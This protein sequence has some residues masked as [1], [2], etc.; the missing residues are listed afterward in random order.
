MGEEPIRILV[1]EDDE[2]LRSVLCQVLESEGYEVATAS[3][4]DSAI[5]AARESAFDLVVADIRMEG[6]SGLDALEAIKTDQP[7]VRSLVI[8]GYSTEADSIR[9]I[10]LGVND[11]LTKPFRLDKFTDSINAIVARHRIERKRQ[12]ERDNTRISLLWVTRL[13][14]LIA[15]RCSGASK[16]E[17]LDQQAGCLAE[18]LGLSAA[19]AEQIR[20]ATL[21]CVLK[22]EEESAKLPEPEQLP[23][24]LRRILASV[25][26][27]WDGSGQPEGLKHRSIPLESRV[28]AVLLAEHCGELKEKQNLCKFDPEI[29]SVLGST[30]QSEQ[31]RDELTP[32][33]RRGLLS[34]G[35]ALHEAGQKEQALEAFRSLARGS[36]V[37][38]ERAEA[39]ASLAQLTESEEFAEQA[40]G[41][42]ESLGPTVSAS[43]LLRAA[44]AY[45]RGTKSTDWLKRALSLFREMGDGV[46]Q[47]T[48]VF[49]L[50]RITDNVQPSMFEKSS[51]F[52]L[53]P[54][55]RNRL[56]EVSSWLMPY[57]LEREELSAPLERLAQRILWDTQNILPQILKSGR[58]NALQRQR[59]LALVKKAGHL[60]S[61]AAVEC[62]LNDPDPVVKQQAQ[63]LVAQGTEPTAGSFLLIR[64]LGPFEVHVGDQRIQ[65]SEWKTRK[66]KF[67]AAWLLAR[68][69]NSL[70]ED[71]ILDQFWPDELEKGKQ[72][73][74]SATSAIRRLLKGPNKTP[75][76]PI[77]RKLGTVGLNPEANS[78]IDVRELQSLTQKARRELASG[79]SINTS[80]FR[81]IVELYRG[82]FLEECYMD[83]AAELRTRISRDTAEVLEA[84]A[85]HAQDPESV[86][87]FSSKLVEIDPW[88]QEARALAFSSLLELGR[89]QRV[90]RQYEHFEQSLRLE[91]ETEPSIEL[92][93][94]YHRAKLML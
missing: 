57:L 43:L 72:S 78:W 90:V 28:V 36:A 42:G 56:L 46:G 8:T 48:T 89:P 83:W 11:Y 25:E 4:A 38:R 21:W 12:I 67:L 74:Y 3:R 92:V 53:R 31:S 47:A 77:L 33:Q 24:W 45:P 44:I 9:A 81:P 82:P 18:R 29:L 79:T 1:L 65:E 20:L 7:D 19:Q 59:L 62:F 69:G 49:A 30:E 32:A 87:E 14:G 41:I 16:L 22:Q 80:L 6:K 85:R 61:E 68:A 75:T 40:V 94:L 76:D 60:P 73:L 23:A 26:E 51:E 64:T 17:Q 84:L 58:L 34:L 5:L 71:R 93:E 52:L 55:N 70:S 39:L 88:N 10:Q 15:D 13:A 35:R 86:N 2:Q 50:A 66:V 63:A 54:E 91:F 37:N 27:R